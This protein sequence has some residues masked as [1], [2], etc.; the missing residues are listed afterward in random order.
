MAM[1]GAAPPMG[2]ATRALLYAKHKHISRLAQGTHN[3]QAPAR[4]LCAGAAGRV[5]RAAGATTYAAAKFVQLSLRQ[6]LLQL[7]PIRLQ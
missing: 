6:V 5:L 7:G 4:R 3:A 2:L 1:V